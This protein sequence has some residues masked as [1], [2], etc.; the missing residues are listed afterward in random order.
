MCIG[1]GGGGKGYD[2][3]K[4]GKSS[5]FARFQDKFYD[6][7]ENWL[8]K[9]EDGAALRRFTDLPDRM[10]GRIDKLSRDPRAAMEIEEMKRQYAI[11]LGKIGI[12]DSFDKFNRKYFNKY[13]GDYK[14][15]YDPQITDQY[16]MATD[17]LT[18]SL[19]DRGMLESSV[20]N[21]AKAELFKD[22]GEAKTNIANEA[23]DATNKLKSS[24]Q[25]Q[26]SNLY[27]INE[28]S[29]DPMGVNAQSIGASTAL[30]APPTYSPLGQLFTAALAPFQNYMDARSNTPTRT[31]RSPYSTPTGS[32]T[33]V[34]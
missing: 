5:D 24:V 13:R 14:D 20:G 17:K 6:K 12:D 8:T 29:A 34:G 28:A 31:Y 33:V 23:N 9:A 7:T 19:A 30:V 2:A 22:Y 27:S 11:D 26:K 18:A 25:S 32:G 16:N 21:A 10:E 15:Y 3:Y 4:G 1:G